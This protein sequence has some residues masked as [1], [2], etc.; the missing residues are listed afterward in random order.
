MACAV[1]VRLLLL[2]SGARRRANVLALLFSTPAA[3]GQDPPPCIS[4]GRHLEARLAAEAERPHRDQV[5]DALVELLEADGD[6]D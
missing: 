6:L 1:R 3:E 4:A 5:D 2:F